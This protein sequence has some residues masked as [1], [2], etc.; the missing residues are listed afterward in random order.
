MLG[1]S[2]N[3]NP[4]SVEVDGMIKTKP[5]DIANH[6]ADHYEQKVNNLRSNMHV[7]ASNESL[8]GNIDSQIMSG[9]TCCFVLP[10]ISLDEITNILLL[11]PE[12]KSPGYDFID[13]KLMKYAAQ[14]I[15]RPVTYLFN[16]SL[17]Q[18][19]FPTEWKQAK[20]CPIPKDA[21][22]AFTAPNSRP[23]SLLS[24]LSKILE[25]VVSDHIWNY[26]ETNN[27][28]T[29]TQHAY[30][31]NHST[32]TVLID[33]T[34]AWLH[35]LDQG[36]IVSIL[37]LDFSA[38]FDLIDHTILV[39]KLSHYG[40]SQNSIN[41][42]KS[43]LYGRK[44]SVY[45]NGSFSS[46]RSTTCGIPQGSCLGPLLYIIYTNDLP[47]VLMDSNANMFADDTTITAVAESQ[48][49]LYDYLANDFKRVVEWV[50]NNK[51]VLN[52]NKTK[53]MVI[54]TNKKRKRLG[55]WSLTYGGVQIDEVSEVKLLG[56]RIQNNLSWT[57]HITDLSK[58]VSKMAG[59]V[60]RIAGL[61]SKD[62]LKV[63]SHSLIYS[64]I[65]YCCVVW[66]N[67]A[68]RDMKSLQITLNKAARM[69]LKCGY[70]IGTSE[71]HSMMGW[72]TVLECVRQQAIA[73]ISKIQM[74]NKPVSIRSRLTLVRDGHQ[75]NTRSRQK[76]H[77]V[78]AKIKTVMGSRSFI[79]W[80]VKL[81]NS[82]R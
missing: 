55:P 5:I 34:D 68:L 45:V 82:L 56:V 14:Y 9:K 62:T 15:A 80:A 4:V 17:K 35:A 28:F 44:Q 74:S 22:S 11:L 42:M 12:N 16:L 71:L 46:P 30:R 60:G 57:A 75:V 81:W 67:A 31:K 24:S 10:D 40:F 48:T 78:V 52:T 25:K 70:E 47:L 79:F 37:L 58:R 43:Y 27:L 38:A 39:K 32:E 54:C 73:L 7:N 72:P 26:M 59:M 76:N 61:I 53:N 50:E 1:R 20:I 63:V 51:L 69:V 65:N 77:Y 23:I 2:N 49:Q 66:G 36:K 6:F 64:H 18:G 41:W 33:M 13:N 19:K 29:H 8:V 21:K 3:T